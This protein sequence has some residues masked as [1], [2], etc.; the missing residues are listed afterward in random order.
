M[1]KKVLLL[2]LGAFFCQMAFVPVFAVRAYPFPINITQPDGTQLTIRLQGDEFRHYQTTEDGYL[3]KQNAK[4]FYTY[5]TVSTAGELTESAVVA[6][7]TTKR[8]ASDLLFLKSVNKAALKA[9][10][11]RSMKSRMLTSAA[12]GP[13]KAYPLNGSPKALVILANFKD[14]AFGVATPQTSFQ[15]LVTQ[16]GYSANGG[17]GSAKDY[18]MASTYGKF[19]PNF[20]VVGP[21]T[22][23]QTLAYYG[24][25]D[26]NGNDTHPDQMIADACAAA[27]AAGLDF[28][29]FDTDNDGSVD[30]VFVYYAGYNEAE[31]AAANT[32][33]P[34]RWSLTDAGFTGTKTF[35]GKIVNDYSCT[36]ELK[37]TTGTNMCG[38]GTFCHEFGHVLGLPDYYDTSGTQSNTLNEWDI[39]DY[40]AYSNSGCTPPAYSAYERFFLGYLTP[41]QISTPSDITLLPLYQGTTQ[42]ANTDNQ[43]FLLSAT[44]HNLNGAAPSPAEFFLVEYRQKTGWDTYLPAEGMCVWH[45]DFLQSQW[46]ANTPNNYTGSTQT[47]ASHM[48]V[49]LQP[50]S[51]QTTTPGTAFTTGSYTPTTWSGT[52]INRPI[53]SITKTAS[54]V[55]FKLMGGQQGPTVSTTGTLSAFST[56]VGTPSAV[57]SVQLSGTALTNNV[58]VTLVNKTNYDIKLSSSGTW[59]KNLT[60]VPTA[61]VVSETLQIRYNPAVAGAQNDQISITSTGAT[62]VTTSLS[63]TATVPFDPNAPATYFGKVDNLLKFPA[64]KLNVVSTK[65]INIKTTDVTSALTVALTG[66]DAALFTVSVGSLTKDAANATAGSNVTITYKPTSTGAH[67]AVLT[68]SGGGLSPDKVI[69]L[70]GSGI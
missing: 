67:T 47:L 40:G 3:V 58:D 34:H 21:V 14:K 35:D 39:M 32:I 4:G 42:P 59:V 66:T 22:L 65:V 27:D 36:S 18:F 20:V 53:T 12:T 62:T 60:I 17:T 38:I 41:Q 70:Q 37:G 55:T 63:G 68:I 19:A 64:T 11:S 6:Q 46:D 13:R 61:G 56:T 30:N 16:S 1:N 5:A 2:A 15:N 29:Q 26:A 50:L 57:Q 45:I 54:N 9:V 8:S 25:N 52:N 28:T 23:P 24:A 69:T 33:W 7:N 31:G 43:A 10:A 49:Y 51:G 44:T 48:R